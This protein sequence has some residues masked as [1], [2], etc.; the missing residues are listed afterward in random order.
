MAL[1]AR[2]CVPFSLLRADA[3]V[4]F[5]AEKFGKRHTFHAYVIHRRC[6]AM[7]SMRGNA[8]FT[9]APHARRAIFIGLSPADARTIDAYRHAHFPRTPLRSLAREASFTGAKNG[10]GILHEIVFSFDFD[11][12]VSIYLIYSSPLRQRLDAAD[13]THAAPAMTRIL[14]ILM[15]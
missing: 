13:A 12:R 5:H 10:A 1:F 4:S 6:F 15:S 14:C 8:H 9:L 11:S 3:A 7:A 2:R